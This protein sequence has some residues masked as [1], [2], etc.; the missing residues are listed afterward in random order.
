MRD[1]LNGHDPSWF[2]FETT[3][4]LGDSGKANPCNPAES[5]LAHWTIRT[6]EFPIHF[7]SR[8]Y[9]LIASLRRFGG[10]HS[11][12]FLDRVEIRLN[13]KVLDG[14][15][16]AV[17]PAGHKDY[18]HQAPYPDVP[19]V[20]PFS[21]CENIYA[22]PI[23]KSHMADKPEQ[24]ISIRLDRDAKWDIDFI[25]FLFELPPNRP[26]VFISHN[27]KDKPMARQLARDLKRRG[28]PVW[29]DE[30]EI[31][32]GDSLL[33]KIQ[34]GID[35]VDYLVVLIS[36]NSISSAWVNKEVEIAMT[37]EIAGK[38]VK[39]CVV[40]MDDVELPLFL[41]DKKYADL[42]DTT[43]YRNVLDEIVSRVKSSLVD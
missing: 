9:L 3:V 27:S 15:E 16:L 32:L 34:E 17:I 28:V 26:Q 12:T 20:L 1:S 21:E 11:P 25:G 29:I 14:F 40:L 8:G 35:L 36:R 19:K 37:K 31:K 41:R 30:A 6:A 4:V 10:L 33:T 38:P 24:L 13:T 43:D 2:P 18:F 5:T 23:P 22:W 42:R 7:Y 39:G